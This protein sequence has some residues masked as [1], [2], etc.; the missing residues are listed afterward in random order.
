MMRRSLQGTGASSLQRHHS[1]TLCP[2]VQPCSRQP[3]IPC[4]PAGTSLG[5]D[6][7]GR[8]SSSNIRSAQTSSAPAGEADGSSRAVTS[9]SQ[10]LNSSTP[11]TSNSSSSSS[12]SSSSS[13]SKLTTDWEAR[14]KQRVVN[15]LVEASKR[16]GPQ[17]TRDAVAAGVAQ[18]EAL[19]PGLQIDVEAMKAS[20]WVS[21]LA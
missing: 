11:P 17:F 19:L 4:Q 21:R 3:R 13:S 14:R 10:A 20:E 18:L 8:A 2:P 16:L 12:G 5:A 7:T 1:R 9:S 6:S 15:D